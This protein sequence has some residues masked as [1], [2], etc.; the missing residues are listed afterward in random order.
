[1]F[2]QKWHSSDCADCQHMM[3]GK[4]YTQPM[5]TV[6]CQPAQAFS[7]ILVKSKLTD[8]QDGFVSKP[9][10]PTGTTS[11]SVF[12]RLRSHVEDRVAWRTRHQQSNLGKLL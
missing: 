9:R 8:T 10:S 4:E 1:M 7:S 2:G 3:F 11:L 5:D 6:S 12:W